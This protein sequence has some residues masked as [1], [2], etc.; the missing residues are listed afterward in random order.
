MTSKPQPKPPKTDTVELFDEDEEK[1]KKREQIFGGTEDSEAKEEEADKKDEEK[2]DA[3]EPKPLDPALKAKIEE[4]LQDFE[5]IDEA[6]RAEAVNHIV[7][8][9]Q[10]ATPVLVTAL[11]G[12]Q[13]RKT[14]V[15]E[16]IARIGDKR[17]TKEL[18]KNL[19]L[20]RVQAARM[21]AAYQA[22]VRITGQSFPFHHQASP[23]EREAEAKKWEEWLKSVEED[24]EYAV[25]F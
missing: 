6:V 25:Q 10:D 19:K 20:A 14:L 22:L 18:I 12:D 5:A 2:K 7:A 1:R 4:L 9:G 13:K 17:A 21:K 16:A 24:E 8:I 15:I 3:A 11:R 23:A